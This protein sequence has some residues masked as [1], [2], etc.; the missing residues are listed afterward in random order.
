[1]STSG[2]EQHYKIAKLLHWFTGALIAFNLL[3]GW[4]LDSFPAEQ[5]ET[6]VAIHAGLGCLIFIVMPVRWWW[7][8]SRRLYTPPGWW[9]QPM[10]VLQWMFYPLVIVQ[11]LLGFTHSLFIGYEVRIFGLL[12]ISDIAEPDAALHS[13]Y[14]GLHGLT[15][16]LLLIMAVIHITDRTLH[17]K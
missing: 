15:A 3:T 9:K 13:L 4:Q 14:F 16:A 6:F 7:R 1:M 12:P 10:F 17:Q 2:K 11:T 5:K 8:S